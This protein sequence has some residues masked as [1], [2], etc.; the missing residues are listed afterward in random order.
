ML[1]SQN[2]KFCMVLVQKTFAEQVDFIFSE[3]HIKRKDGLWMARF[4][5]ESMHGVFLDSINF[6]KA[7]KKGKGGPII[8]GEPNKVVFIPWHHIITL[9]THF[10]PDDIVD[11]EGDKIG[12][13]PPKPETN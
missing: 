13:K 2:K 5:G 8:D 12:F 10:S 9:I 11:G 3:E 4:L 1:E 6:P 7:Y